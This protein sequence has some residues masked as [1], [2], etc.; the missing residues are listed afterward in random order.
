MVYLHALQLTKFT[1]GMSLRGPIIVKP[2]VSYQ[3]HEAH[4]ENA[5]SI[6]TNI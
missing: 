1:K 2:G 5:L 3:M 6:L 4:G